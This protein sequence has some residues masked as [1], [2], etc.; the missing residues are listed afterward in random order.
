M[1]SQSQEYLRVPSRKPSVAAVA[2]ASSGSPFVTRVSPTSASGSGGG[3]VISP[4]AASSSTTTS[5]GGGGRSHPLAPVAT[6]ESSSSPAPAH[7]LPPHSGPT[8]LFEQALAKIN[9]FRKRTLPQ[10]PSIVGLP[11]AYRTESGKHIY[12]WKQVSV[13]HS[14]DKLTYTW[15]ILSSSGHAKAQLYKLPY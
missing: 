14:F 3:S 1:L 2:I 12:C 11:P 9:R 10:A 15:E 4:N 7:P 5:S 6:S 13:R 8:G